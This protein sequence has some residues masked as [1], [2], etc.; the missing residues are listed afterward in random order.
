MLL[1]EAKKEEKMDGKKAGNLR[2]LEPKKKKK[3]LEDLGGRKETIM[4]AVSAAK[5]MAS[6]GRKADMTVERDIEA[7]QKA[8]VL[9]GSGTGNADGMEAEAE[10][11]KEAMK[12][13][14][15][16]EDGKGWPMEKEEETLAG[17]QAKEAEEAVALNGME[18]EVV[19]TTTSINI[20]VEANLDG[21][22]EEEQEEAV[23]ELVGECMKAKKTLDGTADSE[24]LDME[25][26]S[27][28]AGA[29]QQ[30]EEE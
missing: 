7:K 20:M 27:T 14:A 15:D 3:P 17:K 28:L 21:L 26:V 25:A 8:E 19:N 2:S 23:A 11:L 16:M 1:E 5:K 9:N 24:N 6:N 30:L 22:L 29:L 10:A 13:Q 12:E 4:V 18:K